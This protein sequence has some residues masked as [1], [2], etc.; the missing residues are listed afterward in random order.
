MFEL[1]KK[2]MGNLQ[3]M[4]D[5]RIAGRMKPKAAI[6]V[7]VEKKPGDEEDLHEA[8]EKPG[9]PMDAEDKAEGEEPDLAD[10][11]EVEGTAGGGK[12]TAEEHAKLEELLEKLG[13]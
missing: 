10:Q 7:D 6:E 5:D 11:P 13:V 1:K 4:L 3:S 12:L 9:E 8:P 2:V